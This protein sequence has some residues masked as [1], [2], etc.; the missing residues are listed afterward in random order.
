MP[1]PAKALPL[2]DESSNQR[3]SH[4]DTPLHM[5]FTIR[6]GI[7]EFILHPSFGEEKSYAQ[8]TLSTGIYIIYFDSYVQGEC[9]FTWHAMPTLLVFQHTPCLL[10]MCVHD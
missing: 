8:S 1:L 2:S 10:G 7:P 4:L 9:M 6:R 5:C 3:L